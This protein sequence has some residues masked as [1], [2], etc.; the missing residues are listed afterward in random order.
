LSDNKGLWLDPDSGVHPSKVLIDIAA[1]DY[2][3][4]VPNFSAEPPPPK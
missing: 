1:P 3:S 2:D 4:A